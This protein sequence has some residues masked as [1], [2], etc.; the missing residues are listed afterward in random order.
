MYLCTW[1]VFLILLLVLPVRYGRLEMAVASFSLFSWV[2]IS[3]LVAYVTHRVLIDRETKPLATLEQMGR[4]LNETD[5]R[6]II[7]LSFTLASVG[8]MCLIYDRVVLQGIDFS[9]GIAAAR[10][11]WR[12]SGEERQGVS[13]VFSVLGYLFGFTFFV[14]T[15]I[16]HLHWELLSRRTRRAVIGLAA[17]LVLSNSLL[18]GGRSILLIQLACVAATGAMRSMTGRPMLPGRGARIWLS[19]ILALVV[20]VG[21]SIYVFSARAEL[22]GNL[23]ERYAQGMLNYLGGEPSAAF[24]SLDLLPES[25]AATAQFGVVAGSY[26]THSYG[27]FESVLEMGVTPGTVSFG[28]VRELLAKV[29]LINSP[30]EEWVLGGRFLSLPGSLWYDFG[31]FGFYSGAVILGLMM[32]VLPLIVSVRGGAGLATCAAVLILIIGLLA[33]LLLATD[34]LSVP[35]LVIGFVLVDIGHRMWAGSTNWMVISRPT[36]Y[37]YSEKAP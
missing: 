28:F 37:L 20:S 36:R 17:I 10:Q 4:P 5:L 2:A 23:P 3:G 21:Y 6:R 16:S 7:W 9:Q 19:C 26:L 31:W 24:Y 11:L 8:L 1:A 30:S 33:P 22:G 14:A 32:G 12:R 25:L 35:F 34:V 15:T 27:T 18:T 29:G 13:S